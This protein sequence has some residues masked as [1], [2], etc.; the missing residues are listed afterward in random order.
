MRGGTVQINWH[1]TKPILTLDFHPLSGTLATGGADYDIKLW[2]I[3]SG[4]VQKEVPTV[5]YQTSLSYHGSAVNI[6][7]FSPTGEQLASG[8]DGGELIIWKLH[9][10][11][12]GPSWKVLK[13]LSFHRK[14]VLDLQWST[15]GAFLI[16]GSVDNSCIIWD[17]NKGSVHQILDA[18][19]HY[20]QGVAWDPQS[21]YV[22]SLSSDR[23]CRIYVNKPQNKTKGIEKM[24]YVCQHVIT[25]SE[26]QMTDDS[27]VQSVKSHLFHDETLPSFFRRLK[28][29]PDG[30]FLLVP[31][32]SY[33]FSP[34]S[35]PVNTAYVFSRKD[36]SRPA[37]QLPGSSK[38]VIA[39]RF[40][41]M[42]FHLQ[43][44]NSAGFF[45]LPYRL[46]FAVASLNSLYIYD[47][48]SIPPIAILAG[49]HY[50]AITDIAWSHDGKYL[51][52][53]SQD[54]YSTLVEFEN[55]ELGS[56]FLLSEVESVSGD[57]KK[58][59]VQQPKA[60]EVE[61]TTQVVTVSVDSRKRE[62]GR[63]DLKEA[64][65]NATSS[66]T[67]TPKPAKR[68]ITPVS[69]EPS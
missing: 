6:L 55:G 43:G 29:S 19:L 62:V 39:V 38:P 7:R 14:D 36:L 30:S 59:P 37:L 58:S 68:R 26:Q 18:H 17:V 22:A 8:A 1:D 15:D 12:T 51:A 16:S 61:E 53:S 2:L 23:S 46:I 64:S 5:S 28:W 21:K 45:K 33:K 41:P 47:T 57:E 27:K 69:I 49:L 11:D 44:S 40:C 63:N 31:A 52:I 10:T 24:N 67:S 50:A 9:S 3:N 65:P 60:M 32:G 42:A 25:K 56:P 35:G 66:S 20:V 48:E 34:A 4:E 54:G 13:T